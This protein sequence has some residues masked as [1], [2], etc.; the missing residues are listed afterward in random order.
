MAAPIN[1]RYCSFFT[2]IFAVLLFLIW[3]PAI[4]AWEFTPYLN[5][6]ETYTDNVEPLEPGLDQEEY[7]TLVSPGF[8]L[9]KDS[10]RFNLSFGYRWEGLYYANEAKRNSSFHQVTS[11]LNAIVINEF[12]YLDSSYTYQQIITDPRSQGSLDNVAFVDEREDVAS[13]NISPYIHSRIGSLMETELR[14]SY[15]EVDYSQD[16]ERNSTGENWSLLLSSLNKGKRWS[17][18]MSLISNTVKYETRSRPSET[19]ESATINLG[20]VLNPRLGLNGGMGYEK[21]EHERSIQS[22]EPEGRFW[23]VGLTWSPTPR[24]QVDLSRGERYFGRD[25]RVSITHR[26]R[27]A[28]FRGE[29]SKALSSRRQFI[30]QQSINSETQEIIQEL[31][32]LD[33]SYIVGIGTLG[34]DYKARKINLSLSLK[35]EKREYEFSLT[36]QEI[37]TVKLGSGWRMGRRTHMA[38]DL[39]LIQN[40]L[41][42]QPLVNTEVAAME[43]NSQLGKNMVGS[44]DIRR[45]NTYSSGDTEYVVNQATI[46]I[47]MS[48]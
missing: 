10:R 14:Y 21:N 4:R 47:G 22:E 13:A 39:A 18:G 41:Q 2:S 26:G 27:R 15:S 44:L 9:S 24:S 6:S 8:L 38:A 25:W 5:L 17:W 33:E 16:R 36:D 29:Y 35:K 30:L 19:A 23:N 32:P 45:I 31:L 20:Y 46:S 48:W 11:D 37:N 3:S 28:A 12:L 7:V 40:K 1:G 42:G 34:V 43:I